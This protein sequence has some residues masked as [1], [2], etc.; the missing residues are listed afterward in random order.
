MKSMLI[1][2]GWILLSWKSPLVGVKNIASDDWLK[3]VVLSHHGSNENNSGAC[4][5]WL[6][7]AALCRYWLIEYNL[8]CWLAGLQGTLKLRIFKSKQFCRG[9]KS[10]K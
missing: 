7:N 2:L 5:D 6:K 3:S 8:C 4:A 10:M 1:L 9:T